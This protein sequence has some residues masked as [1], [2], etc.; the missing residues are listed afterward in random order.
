LNILTEDIASKIIADF[1]VHSEEATGL[2]NRAMESE[3]ALQSKRII[4]CIIFLSEGSLEELQDHIEM[5]KTDPRD[6]MMC[7]EYEYDPIKNE[8]SRVRDLSL[9]FS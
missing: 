5:A 4:R 3:D 1:G 9:P 6:V 8:E 2:L 7:A